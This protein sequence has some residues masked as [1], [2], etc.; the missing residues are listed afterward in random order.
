[1]QPIADDSVAISLAQAATVLHWLCA[2]LP[3]FV[4]AAEHGV[5]H[6]LARAFRA[7]KQNRAELCLII[8]IR[9]R[10]Q[11]RQRQR[12]WRERQIFLVLKSRNAASG[13]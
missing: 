6:E 10:R 12:R 11:R 2:A 13:I 3:D 9:Q 1:M 4:Q 8:F 5:L 7:H